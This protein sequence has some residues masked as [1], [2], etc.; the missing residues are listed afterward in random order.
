M[1]E[2]GCLNGQIRFGKDDTLYRLCDKQVSFGQ[3]DGN[4]TTIEW[5]RLV[6][7]N[8]TVLQMSASS[9]ALWI[10]D[11]D[12]RPFKFNDSTGRFEAKGNSTGQKIW[13]GN[14][15]HAVISGKDKKAYEW[16]EEHQYWE[17]LGKTDVLAVAYGS[18]N[19]LYKMT[20]EGE[21]FR[22]KAPPEIVNC[23]LEEE[24]KE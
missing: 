17:P 15:G 14:N 22:Q 1:S 12:G 16:H 24:K 10:L 2:V 5:Q 9:D 21:I 8:Q 18:D 4:K 13:A 20:A 7:E 3:F 11:D 23:L 19:R 6:S